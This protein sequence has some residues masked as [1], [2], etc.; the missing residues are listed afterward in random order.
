MC[1]TCHSEL[2]PMPASRSIQG[3]TSVLH[4]GHH[5]KGLLI[6]NEAHV[7]RLI[8]WQHRGYLFQWHQSRPQNWHHL[9]RNRHCCLQAE[10]AQRPAIAGGIGRYSATV[11][12]HRCAQQGTPLQASSCQ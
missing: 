10:T 6:T 4:L 9:R 11:S 7:V 1:A 2:C 12:L 8:C 5:L 3:P